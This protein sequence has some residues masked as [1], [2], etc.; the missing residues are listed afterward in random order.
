[1]NKVIV[2]ILLIFSVSSYA[3]TSE[4]ANEFFKK[5]IQLSDAFDV[6]VVDLYL[7]EAKIHTQRKYPHGLVRGMELSGSKWKQ[8]VVKVMPIAKAQNDKS[9]FSKIT[10]IKQGDGFKVKSNSYSERKCYQDTGYY[11]LIKPDP[12]G[13]FHII[14]EYMET[15]PESNC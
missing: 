6:S 10:I 7:D 1:M 11:M 5:Y 8:L 3:N 2:V 12:K 13:S 4:K 15:Q 14:E 9:T